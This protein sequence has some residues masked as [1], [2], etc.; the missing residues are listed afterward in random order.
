MKIVIN[1]CFGGFGLSHAAV[2]RYAELSGFALYPYFGHITRQVYGDKA[3]FDNP[4][5]PP[6][7][8]SRVP[9]DVLPKNADGDPV[10]PDGAFFYDGDIERA[11]PN[12]VKVVEEMGAGHGTGASGQ[13]ASLKVVEIPDGTDYEIEEYDGL[14]RIAEKH[15]TRG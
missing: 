6:P 11:D 14:E 5:T 13:Y 12:L 9:V 1:K 15:A 2:M 4:D 8:Y 7:S 10:L 3:R